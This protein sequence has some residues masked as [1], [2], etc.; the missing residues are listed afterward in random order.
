MSDKHEDIKAVHLVHRAVPAM[1]V[2]DVLK[3]VASLKAEVERKDRTTFATNEQYRDI[4]DQLEAE[5]SR[6]GSLRKRSENSYDAQVTIAEVSNAKIAELETSL[7]EVTKE[8]GELRVTLDAVSTAA[9]VELDKVIA[10]LGQ[11]NVALVEACQAAVDDAVS[12]DFGQEYVISK[13]VLAK[14]QSVLKEK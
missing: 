10:S 2:N 14:L 13:R 3:E 4:R 11:H 5:V 6:M 12:A 1:D 9:C 7:A 8:V